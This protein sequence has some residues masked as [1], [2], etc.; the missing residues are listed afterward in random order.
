MNCYVRCFLSA[1][2]PAD[3]DRRGR[4]VPGGEGWAEPGG[5]GWAAP[6]HSQKHWVGLLAARKKSHPTCLLTL[7]SLNPAAVVPTLPK[8][9]SRLGAQVSHSTVQIP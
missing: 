4:A 8:T 6:A 7:P 2:P 1:P 5:E 3:P 9:H